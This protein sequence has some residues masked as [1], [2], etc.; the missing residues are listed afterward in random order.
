M[1]H[2]KCVCHCGRHKRNKDVASNVC[3]GCSCLGHTT[4]TAG[5]F[6]K[7]FREKLRK[8]TGNALRAFP[9]IP[10][11]STAGIP[12]TLYFKAFEASRA[13]PEFSPPQYGCGR[14]F[15]QVWFRRGPLRAAHGNPS[16]TGGTSD[17]C[18]SDDAD[19]GRVHYVWLRP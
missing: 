15:F 8:D 13:F 6:R 18:P 1:P 12:Q 19:S 10:V 4:S 11:E 14:L 3:L 7:K 9:G 16:S 5:T 2:L 17:C